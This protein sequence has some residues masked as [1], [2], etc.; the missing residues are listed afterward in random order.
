MRQAAG[1]P[2][3]IAS[4]W[5]NPK[6]RVTGAGQSAEDLRKIQGSGL[7]AAHET[8]P[9]IMVAKTWS[10]KRGPKTQKAA[11]GATF[12]N[13]KDAEPIRRWLLRRLQRGPRHRRRMRQSRYRRTVQRFRIQQR[14][15]LRRPALESICPMPAAQLLQRNVQRSA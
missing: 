13:H 6:Q 1:T 10:Q 14:L 11:Q 5:E 3:A 2:P 12:H 9:D 8:R 4:L 7:A 15:P